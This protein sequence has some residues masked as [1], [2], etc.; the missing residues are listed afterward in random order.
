MFTGAHRPMALRTV[1]R[2]ASCRASSPLSSSSG[3]VGRAPRPPNNFARTWQ[4]KERRR[5]SGAGG[6]SEGEKWWRGYGPAAIVGGGSTIALAAWLASKAS[7]QQRFVAH[8]EAKAA[9]SSR[10]ADYIILGGG[11]TAA[12]AVHGIRKRAPTASVLVI[13]PDAQSV[14]AHLTSTELQVPCESANS[15]HVAR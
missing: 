11:L 4:R 5:S 3:T 14:A 6:R 8:A 15:T 7:T 10:T 12:G 13:T 1:S 2:F 9:S